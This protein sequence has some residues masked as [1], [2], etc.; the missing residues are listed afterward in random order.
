MTVLRIA[1][2]TFHEAAR[3]RVLWLALFLTLAFLALYGFGSYLAFSDA[4]RMTRGGFSLRQIIAPAILWVGLYAVNL[5]GGLLAIFTAV[6]PSP[7][8]SSKEP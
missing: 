6:G 5:M 8:K 3:K 2:F 4:D 1:Q 7:V